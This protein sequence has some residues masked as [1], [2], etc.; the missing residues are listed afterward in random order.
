VSVA[1]ALFLG[2]ATVS[3]FLPWVFIR[4]AA[5]AT[6]PGVLIAGWVLSV[7]GV[8]AAGASGIVVLLLPSHG[9]PQEV[10]AAISQCWSSMRHGG[11]PRAEKLSGLLGVLVVLGVAARFAVIANLL[12]RRRRQDRQ[13]RLAVL[14]MAGRIEPGEPAILWLAHDWPLAFSLPGRPGYVV[15]T[16]GLRRHLTEIQERA[17][18]EHER[19]HLRGRHHLLLSFLDVLAAGLGLLPLLRAA[20]GAVRELIELAADDAAARRFGADVLYAALCRVTHGHRPDS[21][22][23]F[24]RDVIDARLDR[25]AART[26][27][28][29]IWQRCGA[30][31]G[32]AGAAVILPFLAATAIFAAIAALVCQVA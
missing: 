30:A 29:P 10:A 16:D 1:L 18:L 19:A 20:P 11:T 24:G 23:A 13:E 26:S 31:C 5:T 22:L 27:L 7:V 8:L 21:A 15:A 25:L 12:A 17:V 3:W 4:L 14:R 2:A 28:R 9:I 32:F 6:A